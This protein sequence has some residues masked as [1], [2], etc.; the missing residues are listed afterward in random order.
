MEADLR[1]R[2]SS[3]GGSTKVWVTDCASAVHALSRPSE[4]A[5]QPQQILSQNLL[6]LRIKDSARSERPEL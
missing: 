3:I 1:L 4:D 5:F 2:L 6:I